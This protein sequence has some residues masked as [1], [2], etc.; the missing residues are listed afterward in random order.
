MCPVLNSNIKE[1]SLS[2]TGIVRTFRKCHLDELITN[3]LISLSIVSWLVFTDL[4]TCLSTDKWLEGKEDLARS[5]DSFT[6]G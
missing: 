6:Q 4:L 3:L 1:C 5:T 2:R